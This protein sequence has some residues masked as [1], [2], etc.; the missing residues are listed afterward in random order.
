MLDY[1]SENKDWL[2]SGVGVVIATFILSTLFKSKTPEKKTSFT[3]ISPIPTQKSPHVK[4]EIKAD[5]EVEKVAKRFKK[6]LELM[7][8]GRS[9]IKFT[10]PQLA[11]IM[12]LQ[13]ISELEN[14]FTGQEEPTFDFIEHYSNAFGVNKQWLIEGKKSPY[15]NDFRSHSNPMG[16]LPEITQLT[17]E[18]I[19]F[20][21]ENTDAAAAFILL[22]LTEWKYVIF[23]RMWH[24]SDEVGAS[25]QGQLYGFY[26][27]VI[28]LRDKMHLHT[29]CWGLTLDRKEFSALRH[30]DVFPGSYLGH[31]FREDPWWDDLTD[32]NHGYPISGNYEKWYGESFTKAQ[33]IIKWQLAE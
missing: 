7:N 9:Y 25:G 30:G 12:E 19:Y 29:K 5:T 24:I 2:F 18:G 21:R 13:K 20:I 26:K 15:S 4:E 3:E 23:N 14:V 31:G 28:E 11:Q 10:I 17:P 8:E 32:I 33:R 22:E 16:Y 6:T 27:L 1:I